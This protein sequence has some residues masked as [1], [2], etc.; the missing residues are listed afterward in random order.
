MRSVYSARR[1]NLV[2]VR[3]PSPPAF[4]SALAVVRPSW[5]VRSGPADSHRPAAASRSRGRAHPRQPRFHLSP[6]PKQH[7]AGRA[8]THD[9]SAK[10][11]PHRRR[12]PPGP[13]HAPHGRRPTQALCLPLPGMRQDVLQE[14]PP[15]GAHAHTHRWVLGWA[16]GG[17]WLG[18]C[19]NTC[20]P[21]VCTFSS[22]VALCSQNTSS[23][24]SSFCK[25]NWYRCVS[26]YICDRSHTC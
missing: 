10:P 3:H 5:P 11:G 4:E 20:L 16:W 14:L 21:C 22:F 8:P 17:E 19:D 2:Y 7:G 26:N 15:Q 1:V 13:R 24:L 6:D 25:L 12:T 18:P 23:H 9:V